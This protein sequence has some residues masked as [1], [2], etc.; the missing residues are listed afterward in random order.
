[1]DEHSLV[2]DY[3]ISPEK[4]HSSAGADLRVS[5]LR[6]RCRRRAR[7]RLLFVGGDFGRKGACCSERYAAWRGRSTDIVTNEHV[8]DLPRRRQAASRAGPP[9]T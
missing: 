6:R 5:S 8:A 2:E 7:L 4:V 3:G 1:V 9:H